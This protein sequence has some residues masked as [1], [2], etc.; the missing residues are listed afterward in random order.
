MCLD[1]P[2]QAS[3]VRALKIEN[4][5]AHP[6]FWFLLAYRLPGPRLHCFA[7]LSAAVQCAHEHAFGAAVTRPFSRKFEPAGTPQGGL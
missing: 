2:K 5:G 6:P 4:G 3:G 7:A 1:D